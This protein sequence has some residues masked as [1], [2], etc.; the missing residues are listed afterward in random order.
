[1]LW[2]FRSHSVVCQRGRF[3]GW[4][5]PFS[6][7]TP[8]PAEQ[9]Q[10]ILISRPTRLIFARDHLEIP[11]RPPMEAKVQRSEHGRFAQRHKG[12]SSH[13]GLAYEGMRFVTET[14]G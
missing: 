7:P 4:K 5:G 3:H 10:D 13:T 9:L 1:M 8:A 12:E 14:T 6:E 11:W 2:S